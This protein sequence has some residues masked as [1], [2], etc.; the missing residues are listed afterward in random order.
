MTRRRRRGGRARRPEAVQ[1]SSA[2]GCPPA[3]GR[4]AKA[5]GP[6]QCCLGRALDSSTRPA[7][8]S[9]ASRL[10]SRCFA[11]S[12]RRSEPHRARANAIDAAESD[13]DSH[14]NL[15]TTAAA[16]A[17][18]PRLQSE[19]AP[20]GAGPPPSRRCP[21]GLRPPAAAATTVG[22]SAAKAPSATTGAPHGRSSA[23]AAAAP[24]A[25]PAR[26]SASQTS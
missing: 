25:G 1:R 15:L 22:R 14:R 10:L 21:A 9:R 11:L 26:A 2:V 3:P 18:R 16:A 7:S 5:Q 19:R 6:T 17:P 13:V 12:P 20:P 23:V 4:G 24:A 8:A